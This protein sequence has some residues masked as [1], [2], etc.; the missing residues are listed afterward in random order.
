MD[1]RADRVWRK[2]RI[3][4]GV[5]RFAVLQ[6]LRENAKRHG[7]RTRHGL[8][9]RTSVRQDTGELG[10]LRDPATV[11]LLLSLDNQ[12]HDAKYRPPVKSSL[13]TRGDK[14]RTCDLVD[15]NHAL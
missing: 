2:L 7:L 9:S 6:P 4:F 14:I 5:P 3:E 12:L 11:F 13:S 8:I 10:N 1:S 15:P